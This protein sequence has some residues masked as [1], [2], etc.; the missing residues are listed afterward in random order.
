[1]NTIDIDND[2]NINMSDMT[3]TW[4]ADIWMPTFPNKEGI[5]KERIE[6]ILSNLDDKERT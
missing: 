5:R 3:L 6:K 2:G 4:V 1:M